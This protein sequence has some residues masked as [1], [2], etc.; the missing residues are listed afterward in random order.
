[1]LQGT[2]PVRL[3]NGQ[4]ESL[5]Q[6]SAIGMYPPRLLMFAAN[7]DNHH[8]WNCN[9]RWLVCL[10]NVLQDAGILADPQAASG[11]HDEEARPFFRNICDCTDFRRIG[12]CRPEVCDK[13]RPSKQRRPS[14]H[15]LC[16][17][18]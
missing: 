13:Q 7:C 9:R 14:K 15:P 16:F 11:A 1:V 10:E 12:L 17:G 4:F 6:R 18:T 2:R 3:F 5:H 8:Q